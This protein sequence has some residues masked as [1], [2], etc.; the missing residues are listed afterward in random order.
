MA[1]VAAVVIA[2]TGLVGYTWATRQFNHPTVQDSWQNAYGVFDCTVED[3]VEPF[4]STNNPNGIRSRNDGIIYIEPASKSVSGDQ[5]QLGVFIE[6][7]GA[8][9]SDDALTFPDGSQLAEEGA[10]CGG[11][12][13][14]LQVL[15]WA[16]DGIVPTEARTSGLSGTRFLADGESLVV[17][18]AP[19]G[20]TVPLPP[21]AADLAP[22]LLPAAVP[23]AEG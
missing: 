12:E 17:A 15:R 18:L 13:A 21:S 16:P 3:W 7:V 5:A 22:V 9:L 11:E 2:G 23:T 19:L 10:S 8:S 20:A 1:L 14:V 6:N 4:D